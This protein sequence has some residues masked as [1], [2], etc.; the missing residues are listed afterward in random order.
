[1]N[2]NNTNKDMQNGCYTSRFDNNPKMAKDY[3]DCIKFLVTKTDG[4]LNEIWALYDNNTVEERET[5]IK[6]GLKRAKAKE[7]A[8]KPDE[9]SGLTKPPNN[10]YNFFRQQYREKE[11]EGYTKE[12]FENAYKKLKK[13][14]LT[15]LKREH[16][17]L[18]NE[19]N[20]EY[21]RL[22][23]IAIYNGEYEPPK[24]KG[25]C[26]TYALF[27]KDCYS[28]EP[29][30]LDDE[31]VEAF[32]KLREDCK[33]ND[34][35]HTE[36]TKVISGMIKEFWDSMSDIEK[37]SIKEM[38]TADKLRFNCE[39]YERDVFILEA[40][41]RHTESVQDITDA[42]RKRRLKTFTDELT[43]LQET[44]KPE[45]YDEYREEHEAEELPYTS[46]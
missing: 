3:L 16:E 9:D 27:M 21:E 11:G 41:I 32:A 44:G 10:V 39:N 36:N 24:V 20:K 1:M 15:K 42:E 6:K 28:D 18:M 2:T 33:K 7:D 40:K 14:E 30:F 46:I 38:A 35:K 34:K 5:S 23:N 8:F 22:K 12:G 13:A 29:K 4:N 45:G 31:Q 25:A 19:Y 17:K 43:K 37:E 26:T